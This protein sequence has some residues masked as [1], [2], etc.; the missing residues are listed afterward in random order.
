MPG[1]RDGT[2][3]RTPVMPPADQ[4]SLHDTPRT[5]VIPECCPEHAASAIGRPGKAVYLTM[6][7]ERLNPQ[8]PA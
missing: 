1:A 6:R 3:Q 2:N 8:Q 7:D 5:Q 4:A